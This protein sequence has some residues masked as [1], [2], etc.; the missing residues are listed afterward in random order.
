MK[1]TDRCAVV[2]GG[3][4]GIGEAIVER[5]HRD[6]FGGIAV[7]DMD[8][9]AA[10][11]TAERF[12]G[13]DC[14]VRA[15]ACNVADRDQVDEVFAAIERELGP[16]SVLVNNAGITRD[17]MFHK[18]DNA[19]WDSVMAVNLDGVCNTCRAVIAGMR[20]RGYGKIVNLASVS[21]FGNVGQTNY[22]AS[23][24]AV[25]GFTKC[26]ARESAAKNI[27]VNAVAPSYVDTEMLRA[28][29]EQT[30]QRFLDA[31]PAHRLAQPSEIA[32]VVSFLCGDDSSF[33]NG[34]CIVVS[35]GSYT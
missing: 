23:K 22:G 16:V 9:A 19:Q 14:A 7:V 33:V 18:M 17:G 12:G 29:P 26:L 2:T 10:R 21:A 3:A 31:I 1:N 5:L 30:M 27:T 35:G 20:A 28:V 6:G 8:I 25:I 24:A 15:Y 32:A 4:R 34:E 13:G 11:R